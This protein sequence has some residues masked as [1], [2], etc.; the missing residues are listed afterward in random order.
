MIAGNSFF[1]GKSKVKKEYIVNDT[2]TNQKAVTVINEN[3]CIEDME[4]KTMDILSKI[5]GVGKVDVM[6]SLE[7]S[8]EIVPLYNTKKSESETNEEDNEGG[9]RSIF[10]YDYESNLVFED[11]DDGLSKPVVIK[12][13]LPRVNGVVVVAEGAK[14]SYV[15]ER[16]ARA[17]G[18]LFDIEIHNIQVLERKK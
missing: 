18:V 10:E 16:I 5:E 12:E 17:V 6:I 14:N 2:A 1:G 3:K 15:R 9:K 7:S 11:S 13:Y 4:Q 8:R